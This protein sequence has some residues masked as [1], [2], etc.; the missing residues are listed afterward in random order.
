[1]KVENCIDIGKQV[2]ME[3][4]AQFPIALTGG[5]G[6]RVTDDQGK[7]Y[8]DLVAGIAVNAL[9]YGDKKL[10]EAL[11]AVIDTGLLH[12]SNLYWNNIAV[13]AAAKLLALSGM[14]RVFF[15][16]S[17]TEANEAAIKLARKAGRQKDP[18]RT[19]IISMNHS[20]HGRTCG[21][22][23]ATA[24]AKYQTSFLP[25]LPGFSYAPYNDLAGVRAKVTDRTCAIMVEPIQGEGGVVPATEEF[26]KGLRALCDE[27]DLLLIFDEVQCGMGRTGYPF[28]W[29]SYGVR[30]DVMSLAK[31]LGGGVPI[32]A[33]VA[34]GAAAKVLAPGDHAATFG[35]NFL[36]AAAA[37]V[38]LDR[39]AQGELLEQVRKTSARLEKALLSLKDQYP[40][41]VEVRGR[42]LLMGMEMTVP[43]R[44][45]VAACME[46][47]MLI[48]N[49]G[50][51]VLRFVPPL[52]ITEE[53]IDEAV[54]ILTEVLAQADLK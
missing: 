15:C 49:A 26:L 41:I 10:S 8:L 2:F 46:K 40:A 22:L 50:P 45:L 37:E 11:K 27:K 18:L 53:Q 14:D 38:V 32:G 17:G 24:Q 44:P 13:S 19:D 6:C 33:L 36:A 7:S 43:V 29:Q 16:N 4:Y 54:A 9:G 1:M 25:L 42:G 31:A 52:V 21:S 34:T 51:N 39:L 12:C 20:F 35:G 30:P 5:Q 28:A 3:T 48:V 47:G 23:S